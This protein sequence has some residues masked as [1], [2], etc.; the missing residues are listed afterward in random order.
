M[1]KR[2]SCLLVPKCPKWP[3]SFLNPRHQA[4]RHGVWSCSVMAVKGFFRML[5][6]HC[7]NQLEQLAGVPGRPRSGVSV[8]PDTLPPRALLIPLLLTSSW[9]SFSQGC[10]KERHLVSWH[11]WPGI[12]GACGPP[13]TRYSSL[14]LGSRCSPDLP[15]PSQPH[16]QPPLSRLAIRWWLTQGCK[17]GFREEQYLK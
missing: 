5:P 14:D 15:F 9:K 10:E 8:F 4:E 1:E 7:L 13:H 17:E 3:L 16:F 2:A 12:A 11:P 6:R